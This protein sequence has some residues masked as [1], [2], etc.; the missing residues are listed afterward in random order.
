MPDCNETTGNV[1]A[2][3]EP[4][5]LRDYLP[6]LT[7]MNDILSVH[8]PSSTDPSLADGPNGFDRKA[9]M[10]RWGVAWSTL[11]MWKEKRG[12]LARRVFE[13]D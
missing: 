4:L 9:F 1:L 3:L 6:T 7:T 8:K 11:P 12:E 13:Q 10:G 2:P 5:P